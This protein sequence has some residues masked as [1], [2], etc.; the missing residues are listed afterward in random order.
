[1][2]W[3]SPRWT[4]ITYFSLASAP[5]L[6]KILG[7]LV[8][9]VSFPFGIHH[10]SCRKA[11]CCHCYHA[12]FNLLIHCNLHPQTLPLF[13]PPHRCIC[14]FVLLFN[15]N[16]PDPSRLTATWNAPNVQTTCVSGCCCKLLYP[17]QLH[18][19][20]KVTS[21]SALLNTEMLQPS[22][23]CRGGKRRKTEFF[24]N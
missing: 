1:M 20:G 16:A 6:T 2:P 9:I 12:N 24:T 4:P 17:V 14:N 23:M 8:S 21:I 7:L 13:F 15:N 10:T 5:L 19:E 22:E 3:P 18:L 11:W